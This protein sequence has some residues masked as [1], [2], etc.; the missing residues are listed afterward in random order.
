MHPLKLAHG[1]LRTARALGARVHPASPVLGSR[2]GRR[3]PPAHARRHGARA[4]RR[5]R[6]RRLHQ[7]RPAQ[8]PRLEDHADPVEFAGDAA[9]DAEE[10][11]ATNFLTHEVITDTRTLRFYYRMLPDNRLQIGS[12]S[13]IT[14]ADAPNPRHMAVLVEGMHRKFPALKGIEID[15]SW[16]GWVDVSHDMMPRVIQPD[17]KESVFY[18]LG[19]GG[20]GVRF[21]AHAGRRMAE[22]IAGKTSKAFE[23]PIYDSRYSNTRTC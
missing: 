5:L 2:R 22:R 3:A 4:R 11:A 19:Y 1:Y 21:S 17:A 7:Q 8:E 14:G 13:S 10:L 20:N 15:Y 9:A 18:A 16:W 6:H 12:R 23:L